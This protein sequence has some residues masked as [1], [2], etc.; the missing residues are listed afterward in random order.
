[1]QLGM[2]GALGGPSLANNAI[3][4]HSLDKL[5]MLSD[6]DEEDDEGDSLSYDDINI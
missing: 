5:L 3:N 2:G 6:E 1:M 4:P